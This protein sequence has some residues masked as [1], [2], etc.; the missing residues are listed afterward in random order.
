MSNWI[1]RNARLQRDRADRLQEHCEEL[2]RRLKGMFETICA[3]RDENAR[4]RDEL[5]ELRG[6]MGVIHTMAHRYRG[7]TDG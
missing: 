2:H 4:L 5:K 3:L 7:A 6:D 1:G